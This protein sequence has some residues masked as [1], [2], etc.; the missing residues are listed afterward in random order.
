MM[1]DEQFRQW[2]KLTHYV[3]RTHFAWAFSSPKTGQSGR[4]RR[5]RR[6]LD[7]NDLVQE[8][9]L[10]LI[11]A[12][13]RWHPDGGASFKTYAFTAILRKVHRFIDAN[14]CPVTTKNWQSASRYDDSVYDNLAVAVACRLFSESSTRGDRIETV[15]EI[16]GDKATF[17]P[18]DILH[19]DW[20]SYCIERLG[21]GGSGLTKKEVRF[22][23]ERAAGK[24]FTQIGDKRGYTRERAR[25]VHG[26][27]LIKAA[28]ALMDQE[29]NCE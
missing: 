24:T 11:D 27:L 4:Y 3:V 18:E 9:H 10:A 23:L 16:V 2:E 20:V 17:S 1:T 7:Y 15:P 28:I 19:D 5:Y 21:K 25:V 14:A 6:H 8:G 13:E 29:P 22:L 12:W 26:E